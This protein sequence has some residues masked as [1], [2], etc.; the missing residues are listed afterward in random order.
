MLR[1]RGASQHAESAEA[2]VPYKDVWPA[3]VVEVHKAPSHVETYKVVDAYEAEHYI[4]PLV[5]VWPA[6]GGM[7][8]VVHE[9]DTH[10]AQQEC[11]DVEV[12]VHEH[13][14]LND[15]HP[16]D[17]KEYLGHRLSLLVCY[18]TPHVVVV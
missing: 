3:P 2:H 1:S 15:V 18:L 10:Q 8:G 16:T 6:F 7:Q 4:G 9:L 13:K 12:D 14:A 17:A 5:D 11:D